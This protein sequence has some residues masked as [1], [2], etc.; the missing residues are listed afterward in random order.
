MRLTLL[1]ALLSWLGGTAFVAAQIAV[2]SNDNKVRHVNGVNNVVAGVPD[3]ATVLDLGASPPR[4]IGELA[5]PGGWSAPPQSVAVTPDEALALV[6]SSTA[7]DPADPTRTVSNDLV[8]VIDL[9]ARP[10]AIVSTVRA[11]VRASGVSINKQGTLALVAN[12]GEGTVSVLSIAGRT[13]TAVGKVDLKARDSQPSLPVFAPD[14]RTAYVTRNGDHRVSVLTVTGTSVTY[15]GTDISANLNP[16]SMVITPD[17]AVGVVG[18]IGNGPTGGADTLSVLDL[19]AS[20]PRLVNTVSVGLIPEGVS[21]APDGRHVAAVVMNGSNLASS[22]PFFNDSGLLR[23]YRLEGTSLTHVADAR[24]GHWCQGS[25]WNRAGT[26]ILVQ[27]GVERELQVFQFDGHRLTR[28]GRIPVAGS[29]T[30]IRT[31]E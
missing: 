27:C 4:V 19:R 14:G 12:R 31:A 1:V 21:L 16:Y 26:T 15:T 22:S 25:A 30:G 18:N 10:P 29:P 2:S 8:T 24:T 23:L 28:T 17:G 20:P 11:G 7:I 5:V 9:K 3:T 6:V 13:V